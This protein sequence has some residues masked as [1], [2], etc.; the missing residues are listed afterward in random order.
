MREKNVLSPLS[1]Y[2]Y[3]NLLIFIVILLIIF[4]LWGDGVLLKP[5]YH[6]PVKFKFF[7]WELDLK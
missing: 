4:S 1:C 2:A 3:E 7:L 5:E 6:S